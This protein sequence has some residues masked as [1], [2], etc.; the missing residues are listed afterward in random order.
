M[1][2]SDYTEPKP[3]RARRIIWALVNASLFR[4]FPGSMCRAWRHGLLRLFGARIGKDALVY[5]SCKIYAP[6]NLSVGR[7]CIGPHT[8]LYNK[9]PITVGDDSVISQ[10]SFLCTASHDI[11]S[12]MLPLVSRPITVGDKVWI[13]ADC[14]VGP[15]VAVADGC[16]LGARCCLFRSTTP[17]TVLGGNPA[18]V[19]KKRTSSGVN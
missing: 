3:H 12:P 2:L 13:A 6:W 19:I 10:G 4:L 17:Y 1:N 9:A 16:V 5:S 11:S 14:F 15:G 7:A 18:Q 8:E